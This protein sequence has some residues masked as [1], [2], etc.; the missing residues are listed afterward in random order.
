MSDKP[1]NPGDIF[2]FYDQ[3]KG[4]CIYYMVLWKRETMPNSWDMMELGRPE[5]KHWERTSIL[6]DT[7]Y[8]LKVA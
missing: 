5:L 6:T 2:M 4:D 3:Y 7:K 8:Y 1:V